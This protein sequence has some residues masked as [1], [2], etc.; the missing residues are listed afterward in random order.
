MQPKLEQIAEAAGI[1]AFHFQKLFTE[2]V[3]VS[4]KKYVQHLSLNYAKYLIKNKGLSLFD[5]A[6]E[7]GLSGPSRLHNL[8][9]SIEAMSAAE[10]KNGGENLLIYFSYS[11]TIFGEVLCASTQKGLC[12]MAF[13]NAHK[14]ELKRLKQTYKNATLVEAYC[15]FHENAN[16]FFK[17]ISTLNTSLILH[18]KASDFQLKVWNSL[19]NIPE[20]NL[21]S[22]GELASD[23]QKPNASRA[24]GTAVGANPIAYIIPCHRVIQGTGNIGGYMWGADRKNAIIAWEYARSE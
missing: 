16:K 9:V 23:I 7:T 19:L 15:E 12:F 20:A 24:V 18:I 21:K 2:M 14:T 8:F 11:T 17:P 3:G 4:P 6:F 22:Y 5:T 10:F 13:E 1:S